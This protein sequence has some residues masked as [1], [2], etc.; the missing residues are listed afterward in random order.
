MPSAL[1]IFTCRPNSH[2]FQERHVYLDE[3]VKIGRSVARCRPAQN[4]ATFDCKVLSRNHALVWFD[5]KTGK[6]YLQD[7]KSS[8]GTFIN[9]QRLSRGS[10][11][12]PPCEI[13][14]GDIIQFGVD[15]TENTRKVTHGCI[16]STIKLF[17][18]D[19]MEARL[20]SDVIHAPL[21]SPVDKVAANTPSMYS[22]ELFQLSQ[23][24]QEALHREQMLEQKL[25]TL[26]RLLAVTQE[27]S[28][29]SWQALIDEDRLLSR[30]E[31]MGNQLQACSKNQTEDS[32]RKELI[33]LQEDKHNYET[34]AKESLRRVLQEKI[35]VVRKLSEVERSLSNTE[36]ECTHL[37][38]M[39]ERTQEELRELA[40][41][42]NGAVNEIKDLS[43]KL[44]VAEG[45]QEEIQQKGL[46][47]K[48]ELQHKIDEMEERE[49]ELQ[50]KIE[51]LQ[52]DND[53]TNE[54]LTALQVRLE[55]LQEKT[56]KEHN[57]LGIQVDD[58]IP[59]I[60]G[61]TE[62]DKIIDEGHLTKVEET[63]LLKE[64]Q[65]RVKESNDLSDTLSPSK[66]KS[67]DDTTDAQMDDQDLNEP[68]A[69]VALLK[70]E[71]QGAQSETEAKQEIQQ[72]HKELIE[73]QELART[74]K[75]KCF[76]LQALLEEERKAYRV[77]V[78][79][80]NKQ[81]NALQAQLRRLQE[82]IENLRKEKENEISSTRN[83]LV[84]A[85]N[86]ILSLQQV[87][88]KAASE[89]DTDISTLQAELQTVRA[90]LER[91]RKD[92][93]DYEKEIVD[94]QA[95]FQLRCQQ[96][97]DQQKEEA[98]RLKG[99]LEK[100]KAE[101]LALEAE[102]VKLRKENTLLTSELQR[103]EKELSSSQ[104]Q[105]LALTSDISV[106]EMSRKE[107]ENQM[108]SLRE[109]HQRDAASLKTQLSEAESQAKDVQKEYERTQTVL[110]EL[111]AKYEVA[112]QE[113]QSLTEE[114]KQ[115]KENLKLLQEKGNNPSILQPVPA[116]FIGLILAFLY[117]CYGPLW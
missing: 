5:H 63:K 31:V 102:C 97:E 12:S 10:E 64:N 71:L 23:Y 44:K 51:A 91:W 74:S 101:W 95:S 30:L 87:A 36:D 108:G 15:V 28:D 79:E 46:A 56:L 25:A 8:N 21:P 47:E 88:E 35:E 107:L 60:N 103:Q 49:Q 38:E 81:I 3:P 48:K 94:L 26:Q 117:W 32:I 89:R 109:K 57:S 70:D 39:N 69:K 9:S 114:L 83:E 14:S 100:L 67:S 73:A 96:C 85:Q 112:E 45:R 111:K 27:A 2:P 116:V 20:R 16:V 104:K 17:L 29:T 13:M 62:K 68:I 11:E 41:K 54:R 34:T 77:Q 18:P 110:S 82:E 22:Q 84:S 37:K 65:A 93:S 90:E 24:L 4:N 105:S 58:F 99:E 78:E 106:L 72:L 19:G 1:A 92:A 50:A 42:Y 115:C 61:S 80:S 33:A 6:F 66:E 76:E 113:K 59:K 7:T 75:Q 86:E 40:N 53:F 98:T 43:D 52:A 55:H